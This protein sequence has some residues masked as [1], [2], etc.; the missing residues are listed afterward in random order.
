MDK[1][2]RWKAVVAILLITL[3]S[4]C[5]AA[6]DTKTSPTPSTNFVQMQDIAV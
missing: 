5:Q 6:A 3:L 4:A 1:T 2:N